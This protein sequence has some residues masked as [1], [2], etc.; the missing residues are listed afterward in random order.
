MVFPPLPSTQFTFD[1]IKH[2][3]HKVCDVLVSVLLL[4]KIGERQ[5][6]WNEKAD[7]SVEHFETWDLVFVP[8]IFLFFPAETVIS[9]AQNQIISTDFYMNFLADENI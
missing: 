6:Y 5:K 1:Q 4:D 9:L 2:F 7:L 8:H 3:I